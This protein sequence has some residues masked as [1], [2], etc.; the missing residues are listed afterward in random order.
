M[1]FGRQSRLPREHT[2]ARRNADRLRLAGEFGDG[3]IA[4][5]LGQ[6]SIGLSAT[7]GLEFDSGLLQAKVAAP[8]IRTA[9][10]IGLSFGTGLRNDGG[11]LKTKDS[12]IVHDDLFGFVPNEHAN[13]S[14]VSITGDDGLAG[15]GDLTSSRTITLADVINLGASV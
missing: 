1:T 11:T 14:E 7:P 8:I 3:L 15:G 13:H 10:G 12:E 5:A 6:L 9:S 4:N 2:R